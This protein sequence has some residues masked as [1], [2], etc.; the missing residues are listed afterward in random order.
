M[1][2]LGRSE[3]FCRDEG[4]NRPNLFQVGATSKFLTAT[5]CAN[6]WGCVPISRKRDEGTYLMQYQSNRVVSSSVRF[7]ERLSS[8]IGQPVAILPVV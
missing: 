4:M 1:S 6:V 7:P 8:S 3:D 5:I 2:L